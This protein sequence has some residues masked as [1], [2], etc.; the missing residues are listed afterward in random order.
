MFIGRKKELEEIKSF[1]SKDSG[2]IMIYGKRKVGKTT[3]INNALKGYDNTAYYECI[4]DSLKA[5]IDGLVEV[6]LRNKILPSRIEFAS[7]QDLFQYLNSLNGTVNIVID[8]YPY[9]KA[10]N[11]PETVDSVFQSVIDNSISNIHLFISGSHISMMRNLLNEKNALYGR[12]SHI[13]QLNELNYIDAS[14]FYAELDVYDKVGLYSVFGGSP[15]VNEFIENKKSLKDN[16]ISTI[17]NP[18]HSVYNYA[19]NLLVSDFSNVSGA[20]RI[21][22]ALKNGK[23]KY[24]EIEQTLRIEKNGALSKMLKPLLNM[25]LIV[26]K[27]PINRPDDKKKTYYE[28]NDNLLRFYY[29]YVYKNKSALQVIGAEAFYEEYISDSI[30]TFISHRFEEICRDYFSIQVKRA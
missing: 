21:F 10:T 4:K 8:E 1:L 28:I 2:C 30:I 14:E 22:S 3:L 20:E 17:L 25:E 29:T 24:S 18:S 12:F 23:K 26:K 9:L 27:N 11:K 7:F 19:D 6:L 15:F 5:N 13:I 16:I